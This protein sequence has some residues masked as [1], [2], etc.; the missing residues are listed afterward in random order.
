[1]LGVL[2]L[3]WAIA[4]S[5]FG[6][7]P[8]VV[9]SGS[10][11]PEIA[12][13]DLAL[14]RSAPADDLRRGD[15]VSVVSE[16]G[17]RVT[18]RIVAV[19]RS[20][21]RAELTLQGDGNASPD[22]GTYVV[23][24]ADR[25]SAHVPKA[26]YV[27]S[28]VAS[29]TGVFVGGLLVGVALLAAFGP[30]SGRPRGGRR[31]ADVVAAGLVLVALGASTQVPPVQTTQ[32]SFTDSPSLTTGSFA[33]HTVQRPDSASCST[34]F[35]N[36]KVTWPEKDARYDYEVVLRRVSPTAG[37]IST[38]QI[39][40]SAVSVT[41]SGILEF[42]LLAGLGQ[43]FQVDIRSKLATATTWE[44]ATVWTYKNLRVGVLAIQGSCHPS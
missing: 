28:A 10:M 38:R 33:A 3:G 9:T 21:N 1:V 13:G 32:A 14:G 8:L 23:T 4:M 22:T 31:R 12:T 15:V 11:A 35:L 24:E 34:G 5:V 43:E 19:E 42:G 39:T 36:V 40:G 25:V 17:V 16:S 30:G 29:P 20:D 27:V 2:C 6:I 41:Y 7:T 37:V 18:H 44:S 26:G